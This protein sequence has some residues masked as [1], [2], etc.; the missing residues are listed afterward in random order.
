M[1]CEV[2]DTRTKLL[3]TESHNLINNRAK[4][5]IFVL[6]VVLIEK[7]VVSFISKGLRVYLL[8]S[9]TSAVSSRSNLHVVCKGDILAHK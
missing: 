8:G 1:L 4:N 7:A 9:I 6:S 5:I 2:L 3:F